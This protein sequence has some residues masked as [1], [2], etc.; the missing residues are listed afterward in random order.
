MIGKVVLVGVGFVLG[1][2]AGR[3]RYESIASAASTLATR[4]DEY[5]RDRLAEG[6]LGLDVP[7]TSSSG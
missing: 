4:L 1:A 7:K 2:R 3:E 5:S 6:R